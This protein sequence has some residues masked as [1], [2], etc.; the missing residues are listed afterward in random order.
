ML[1]VSREEEEE[2]EEERKNKN[3]MMKPEVDEKEEDLATPLYSRTDNSGPPNGRGV[4][5][6]V[7]CG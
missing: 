5:L 1:V 3:K 6:V 2:T 4:V 7:G